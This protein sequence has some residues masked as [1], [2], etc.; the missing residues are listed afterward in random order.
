MAKERLSMRKIVEVLRLKHECRLK[1]RRIA[2]S[3]GVSRSTVCDYLN[4]AQAAGMGAGPRLAV[5]AECR[6]VWSRLW[7]ESASI[8]QAS[9]DPCDSSAH[10]ALS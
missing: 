7:A 6:P 4:R 9:T 10:L 1:H 8:Q 3:V 5:A 2:L